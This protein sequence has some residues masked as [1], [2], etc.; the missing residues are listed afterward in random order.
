[1]IR[2][3]GKVVDWVDILVVL[4][5]GT[6]A[7]PEVASTASYEVDEKVAVMVL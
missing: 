5:A 2:V 6:L 7:Y 1:M 3:D 4:S